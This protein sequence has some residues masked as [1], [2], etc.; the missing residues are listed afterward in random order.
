MVGSLR[1]RPL[2]VAVRLMCSRPPIAG[3]RGPAEG[4]RRCSGEVAT[5]I[6]TSER[7]LGRPRRA[8]S[9]HATAKNRAARVWN[10]PVRGKRA[11]LGAATACG[12][13]QRSCQSSCGDAVSHRIA[14][15]RQPR[16][17]LSR[18]TVSVADADATGPASRV[19]VASRR[20]VAGAPFPIQRELLS[21]LRTVAPIANLREQVPPA[22]RYS[23][24]PEISAWSVCRPL[25][26][27]SP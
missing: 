14:R 6:A 1:E 11:P 4:D 10:G 16:F 7:S 23:D 24:R 26:T 5:G 22:G 3:L 18:R 9:H 27:T 21:G 19:S 20:L 15:L 2:C 25:A 12:R 13:R 8:A 17:P